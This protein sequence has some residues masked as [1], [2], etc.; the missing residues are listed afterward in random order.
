V[1]IFGKKMLEKKLLMLS[2]KSSNMDA[3]EAML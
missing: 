1:S 3:N 2:T